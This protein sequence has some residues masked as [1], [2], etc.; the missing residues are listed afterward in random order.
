[1]MATTPRPWRIEHNDQSESFLEWWLI[2][3]K[4][5]HGHPHEDYPVGSMVT[6]DDAELVIRAVNL[7]DSLESG[8][9][10]LCDTV[11]HWLFVRD[12]C[13]LELKKTEWAKLPEYLKDQ[14]RE[15]AKQLLNLISR[16]REK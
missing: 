11:A 3:P 12:I 10:E 7:L 8:E 13:L 1:M 6:E 9:S 4:G 2:S 15:E 5:L 14:L 16:G